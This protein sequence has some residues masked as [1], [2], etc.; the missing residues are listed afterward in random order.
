M[1]LGDVTDHEGLKAA[2]LSLSWRE[3]ELLRSEFLASPAGAAHIVAR[4]DYDGFEYT[5]NVG[6][7]AQPWYA[8]GPRT[9]AAAK[10]VTRDLGQ[11]ARVLA[12]L[13]FDTAPQRP[14]A[15]DAVRL[16]AE[17]KQGCIEPGAIGVIGGM[18][19][20]DIDGG[21]I[22]F[23]ASTY[24]DDHVVRCSG[25]PATIHTDACELEPTGETV[26]IKVWRFKNG[27]RRAHNDESYTMT[28]PL[29]D[30]YPAN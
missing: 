21:S 17:W 3:S 18:V 20:K 12:A 14:R 13:G 19:G 6:Q 8:E 1:K 5:L 27:I 22:T 7:L 28:V 29:W 4:P 25:S 23:N 30:W 26:E 2:L 24:R 9:E 16:A 15:G 10:L 11:V